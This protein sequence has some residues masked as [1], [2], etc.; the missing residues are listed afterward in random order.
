MPHGNVT[1]PHLLVYEQQPHWSVALRRLPQLAGVKV[2]AV[3]TA[4]QMR[5]AVLRP[6]VAMAVWEATPSTIIELSGMLWEVRNA[7][8]AL[9]SMV[10][11]HPQLRC[12]DYVWRETGALHVAYATRLLPLAAPMLQRC[13]Q[14]ARVEE[15]DFRR[16][17]WSTLPWKSFA[18]EA[19]ESNS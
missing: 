13:I 12:I 18:Q 15:P 9:R 2:E 1:E 16:R 17:T 4:A 5:D 19:T 6:G 3:H 11:S 14:A 10:C 8:P 7:A